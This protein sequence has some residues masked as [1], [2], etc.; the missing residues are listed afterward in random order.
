M[1]WISFITLDV[2][3]FP[4]KDYLVLAAIIFLALLALMLV[5]HLT[6]AV[7]KTGLILAGIA[8]LAFAAWWLYNHLEIG[9]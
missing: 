8:V 5:W 7:L 3:T 1:P 6:K 9:L 2:G 4:A